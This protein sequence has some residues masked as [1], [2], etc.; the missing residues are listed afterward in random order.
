MEEYKF[1]LTFSDKNLEEI[2]SKGGLERENNM[3][4]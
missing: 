3:V 2:G 4:G 1:D